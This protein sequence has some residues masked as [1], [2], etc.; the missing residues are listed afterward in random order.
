MATVTFDPT[1]GTFKSDTGQVFQTHDQAAAFLN[2]SYTAPPT[3]ASQQ[4]QVGNTIGS[5]TPTSTA[6]QN[7]AISGVGTAFS[8]PM[9][10]GLTPAQQTAY[11]G[12]QKAFA[13]TPAPTVP[14]SIT[15]ATTSTVP[16]A[17]FKTAQTTSP[18]NINS[19][20]T[21]DTSGAYTMTPE[22]QAVQDQ[23]NTITGLNTQA[24]GKAAYTTEQNKAAGV[25][26]IQGMIADYTGQLQSLK[27]DAAAIDP[28]LRQGASDRG[29]TTPVLSAQETVLQR[30]NAVKALGVAA[31]LDAANGSLASAR[32]KV[33]QAVA[34]KY[35]PIEADITARMNNLQLIM[36]SPQYTLAEKKQA[37]AQ[38]A[39]QQQNA[40]KIADQKTE[41][42]AIWNMSTTAAT[43]IANFTPTEQYPT[44]ALAL[45]AIQESTTKEQALN[46]AVNTGLV[47]PPSASA[48]S[49]VEVGGRKLLINDAT[50]A[51]IKDL[52]TATS[53]STG[54]LS[55]L[56]VAR[57][58][59]L[60]PDAGVIAGD[61]ETQAN[62][63]VAQLNTPEA[64]IRSKIVQLKEA[65]TTYE[66]VVDAI[67]N[68]STLTDKAL[69]L[70]IAQEVYGVSGST[71]N[72]A[73]QPSL[74][75][76]VGNW[77][78]S[79]FNAIFPPQP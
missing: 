66:E 16:T 54:T 72:T 65:E 13:P 7:T 33:E 37:A 11:Q 75:S 40:Q 18:T 6:T 79:T 27:A 32:Y 38:L 21:T 28:R 59:E 39:I 4:T 23:I 48:T 5:Y 17:D 30:A 60:Y 46:I 68:D 47:K 31:L 62:T 73:T 49:I 20:V 52:G 42:T 41:D 67:K 15:S 70:K 14:S 58:N 24:A 29:V 1:S 50:G 64:K 22:Q 10:T 53:G 9:P 45:K 63:K 35:G 55:V 77:I 19:I 56:D 3:T 57:Y 78:T 61:T 43:N 51:T 26:A 34:D 74:L 69:A 12:V 36:N 8:S 71:A 25:P 76:K 44:A 2:P